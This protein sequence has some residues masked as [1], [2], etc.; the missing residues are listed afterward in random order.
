[1][2]EE[3]QDPSD[4]KDVE[5]LRSYFSSVSELNLLSPK[6][7]GKSLTHKCERGDMLV[8]QLIEASL[9]EP[10]FWGQLGDMIGVICIKCVRGVH[11]IQLMLSKMWWGQHFW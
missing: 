10:L 7:E 6:N 3:I 1:M 9:K 5:N 8:M 4:W 2:L 11:M